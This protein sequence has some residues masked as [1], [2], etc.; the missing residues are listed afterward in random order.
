MTNAG[1]AAALTGGDGQVC[2]CSAE[3]VSS[4]NKIAEKNA[5]ATVYT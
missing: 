2:D 4:R 1:C 3:R 5:P